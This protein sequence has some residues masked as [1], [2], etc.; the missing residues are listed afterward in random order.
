[1]IWKHCSKRLSNLYWTWDLKHERRGVAEREPQRMTGRQTD[2][3]RKGGRTRERERGLLLNGAS[4]ARTTLRCKSWKT[5]HRVCF[6]CSRR[7]TDRQTERLRA[8]VK[9]HVSSAGKKY[10]STAHSMFV[11]TP[12]LHF[13]GTGRSI[14]HCVHAGI[15]NWTQASHVSTSHL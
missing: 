5:E 13:H 2:R 8:K 11:Y 9:Q 3:E 10:W 1:M 14:R 6:Q 12:M 4:A 7:Q 15:Q